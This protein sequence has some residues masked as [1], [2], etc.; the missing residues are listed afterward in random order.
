MNE[1][2]AVVILCHMIILMGMKYYLDILV[3]YHDLLT[4]IHSIFYNSK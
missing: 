4:G 2:A 3:F 1:T